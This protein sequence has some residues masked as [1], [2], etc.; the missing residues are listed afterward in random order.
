MIDHEARGKGLGGSDSPVVCGVSPFKTP[1]ELWRE[2]VGIDPA[3]SDETPA[4]QR[5]KVLEPIVA[6]LYRDETGRTI[7]TVDRTLRHPDLDFLLGH[8]DREIAPVNSDGPGVLEIKCPGLHIFGKAQREGLPDYYLIQLMHYLSVTGY[9]WGSFAV[10]NSE[11]WQLIRFDVQR[12]NELIQYIIA[13][14]KEFWRKV[15]A[16]EYPEAEPEKLDLPKVGGQLVTVSDGKW[17]AIADRL[18]MAH[19][20]KT[21][22]EDLYKAAQADVAGYMAEIGA[23]VVEGAGLRVYNR[24]Q[25]GRVSFDSKRFAKDHPELY[26]KYARSGKPFRSFRPYFLKSTE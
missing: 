23:D 11:R 13:K 6:D 12:D 25:D 16:G 7:K 8:I 2:K 22:A 24:E 14:D 4:M 20:L 21:E 17:S 3:G 1:I 19:E 5:G 18:R 26:E 10:F 15:L 9:Q